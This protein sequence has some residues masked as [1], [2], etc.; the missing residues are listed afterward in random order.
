LNAVS[1]N[2]LDSKPARIIKISNATHTPPKKNSINQQFP[3]THLQPELV[4]EEV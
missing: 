3:T 4:E 1:I 2:N